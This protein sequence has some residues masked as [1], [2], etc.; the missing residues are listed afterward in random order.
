MRDDQLNHTLKSLLVLRYFHSNDC[1][2]FLSD[3]P[4]NKKEAWHTYPWAPPFCSSVI[5]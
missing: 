3:I 5:M 4:C 2:V 1:V